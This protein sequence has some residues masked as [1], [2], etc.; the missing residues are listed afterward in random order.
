MMKVSGFFVLGHRPNC[1][2]K[3]CVPNVPEW[4]SGSTADFDSVSIS[5]ILISGAKQKHT[6]RLIVKMVDVC[7]T[8]CRFKSYSVCFCLGV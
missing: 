3:I 7:A 1:S 4:C 8:K 2:L 6:D 5:S